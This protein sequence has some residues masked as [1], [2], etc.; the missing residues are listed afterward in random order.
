MRAE[1][2]MTD[3]S[4]RSFIVTGSA[5]LTYAVKAE[6]AQP[7]LTAGE[8]VDRIRNQ[9][10]IPWA[11]QT[12]D[13][14]VAGNEST[15]VHGIATTMMATLDVVERA[16]SA[17]KNLIITHETPY[18]LHQD[19]TDDIKDDPTLGYKLD[20]MRKHNMAIFHFHDHWH[21]RKPD[22]IATGMMRQLGWEK[23]VD[24]DNP[25]RF[26]FPGVPLA[27]FCLD[28][29]SR[30]KDR[31]IRVVG[32]PRMPV[33]RVLASW[34]FVSRMPG[35]SL[36]AR[37]D[38][39]VFI[40]G[41]TREWELVEYV[42]DSITAGNKKALILLGHVAS[43]QGGMI[44]CAEW[45]RSFIPEVPIEFIPTREPFWTPGHPVEI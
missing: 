42:R 41:E 36:F 2:K 10:G 16:A 20:F 29:Q 32:D 23:N 9:V 19:Q 6:E 34:G 27:H 12:V 25:K 3:L 39:D 8:I 44:Y 28:L 1:D 7:P 43:E 37:P 15:P 26:T 40:A 11:A 18:Y 17:G 38:V 30:L 33:G 22:G 31:A 21:A 35:I 4:R 13:H 5:A 14:I 45:L 24:P